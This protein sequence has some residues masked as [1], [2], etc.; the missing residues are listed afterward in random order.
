MYTLMGVAEPGVMPKAAC[1][2]GVISGFCP[3]SWY[4]L[5]KNRPLGAI[6]ATEWSSMK[7]NS[8]Y[9]LARSLTL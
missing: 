6:W 7:L 5:P 4:V 1:M 2:A 9:T 8:A 3:V